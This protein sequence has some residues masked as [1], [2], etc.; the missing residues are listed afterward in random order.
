[1]NHLH[2]RS[3]HEVDRLNEVFGLP[4]HHLATHQ[5]M[6]S[7]IHRPRLEQ[8][9][10]DVSLNPGLSKGGANLIAHCKA[11]VIRRRPPKIS[12][13]TD[14]EKIDEVQPPVENEPPCLP[15]IGNKVRIPPGR[16]GEGIEKK[17][18]KDDEDASKDTPP[19]PF[20]HECF[21]TLLPF[22]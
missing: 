1:M 22:E 12:N 17:E 13:E 14:I 19:K 4:L 16:K 15:M 2:L 20:V 18:H 7:Q 6:Q 21:D 9:E 3:R 5:R 10:E 8:A 11:T